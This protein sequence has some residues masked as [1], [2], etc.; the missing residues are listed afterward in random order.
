MAYQNEDPVQFLES[1]GW[2]YK[3]AGSE[4][5][6]TCPFCEEAGGQR[7]EHLYL[8]ADKAVWKCHK[9][10]ESG[11]L[12]Q[13]RKRLGL[14]NQS[15]N[16]NL[17][18]IHSLG[19]AIGGA[20]KKKISASQVESLHAALLAD[21]EAMDYCIRERRWG[22]EVVKTMKLGLRIDSRGKWLAYPYWRKGQCVALKYRILPAYKDNYPG[23]FERE[24]GCESILFN[25]DGLEGKEEVI[26]ASGESDLLSLLTLGFDSAVA[27]STGE[28]SLPPAA[29]DALSK[30]KRILITYDNDAAGQKGAREVAKRIGYDKTL[31]VKLP[32]DIHDV[33]IFLTKGG[34][35]NAFQNI[36][37]GACQ[38]DVPSIRSIGQALD[39]LQEEKAAGS[40]DRIEDITPW[41]SVNK[42][43]GQWAAGNLIVVS[44]PQGTGKTTWVLN[45]ASHWAA[46]FFPCLM[47]CLEM[48]VHELVQHVLCANY[49]L[50]EKDITS[51]VIG[52]AREDLKDWPLYLGAN[53]ALS[54]TKEVIAL[55]KQAIRRYGLKLVIFDNLHMLARSIDHRSEEVGVISKSFKQLAMELEVPIVLLA[56]PRKLEPGR[57]M[58]SWDLKDSVDIFSDADQVI[59]LHRE[60]LGPSQD[61]Q[62]VAAAEGGGGGNFDPKTLI[63]L[64]KARHM[65][66]TDA[67]LYFEGS[68]HR[69]REI[70]SDDCPF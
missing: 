6:V 7:P 39:E 34:D 54:G 18:G 25:E 43:L 53:P 4:F 33:N 36:L 10:G 8:H 11:N 1:Q 38:F 55:L 24:A 23:R 60:H 44:G 30:M 63:R 46:K 61:S 37:D 3:Q 19:D 50:E 47:Y 26:L 58:T 40:A 65:A 31:L 57:V 52:K 67:V 45:I 9:C 21:Q 66:S 64:A 16:G 70:N 48:R 42:R 2:P 17:K 13:L 51:E 68:Q 69:F 12:Y 14:P 35:R 41:Y 62:A 32:A 28:S 27:T 15:G 59:L 29:V 20:S 56:Q 22:P 49:R 5:I